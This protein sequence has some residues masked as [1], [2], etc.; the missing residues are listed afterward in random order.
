MRVVSKTIRGHEPQA[1]LT[2]L[3]Q[4]PSA[5]Q[6]ALALSL[7]SYV[8]DDDWSDDLPIRR[9]QLNKPRFKCHLGRD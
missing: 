6:R 8:S 3:Q 9:E 5:S 4:N 2:I 1:V 7:A